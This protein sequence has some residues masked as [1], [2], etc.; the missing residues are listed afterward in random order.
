MNSSFFKSLFSIFLSLLIFSIFI[1]CFSIILITE[2]N[3]IAPTESNVKLLSISIDT[4]SFLWPV[5]GY[6]RISSNFGVRIAPTTGASTNH[7]GVDIPAPTGTNLV[8]V[9]DGI[10]TDTKWERCWWL[11]C[12]TKVRYIYNFLLPC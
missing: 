6:K 5:P 2:N 3:N 4:N 1:S 8:S 9:I 12:Y 11:Y 10:I 7:S